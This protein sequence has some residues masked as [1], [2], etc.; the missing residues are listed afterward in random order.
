MRSIFALDGWPEVRPPAEGWLA[1]DGDGRP[2]VLAHLNGA[3]PAPVASN[4]TRTVHVVLAGRLDNRQE[5]RAT[6]TTRHGF[7]GDDD[8]ELVAHLY[9]ERGVQCLNALRGAF[10]L[11]VWDAPRRLMLIARDQ[12][13]LVPLFYVSEGTRLAAASLLPPLLALPGVGTSWDA[14]GLDAF[15]T[16]GTVP[17]PATLYPAVRQLGPGEMLLVEGRRVRVQRYW[18]LTFPERR[19]VTAELAGVLRT[20]VSDALRLRQAGSRWGLL[21]SGGLASAALLALAVA[22]RR[23]PVRAITA[24]LEAGDADEVRA[25]A[26]RATEA[27]V[28]HVVGRDEPDW[29]AAVDALLATH[30]GPVGG[31]D[32]AVLRLA[33]QYAGD[34]VDAVIAGVGAEEVFGG[35][36][37]AQAAARIVAYRRLPALVRESAQVW[38]RFAPG[39]LARG[40]R[41]LVVDERLAP[42]EMYARAV[43]L[44]LPEERADLYTPEWLS[45]LGE[46]RPW[47][48][49]TELFSAAVGAGATDTADAIH[50]AELVLR[51]PVRV[52]ALR[53]AAGPEIRLPFAD[54]RLAQFVASA[55]PAQRGTG[56][57]R[58]LLL[59][60]AVRD[61]LPV[62][63]LRRPHASPARAVS[64]ARGTLRDFVAETLAPDRV[65]AQGVFRPET[66]H[67]LW[68]EHCTGAQDH[69]ARLWALVLATRWLERHLARSSSAIR[70]AG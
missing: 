69:G 16:F 6:L 27:G 32:A 24:G 17:P 64:L 4:E 35:S 21:L 70:A 57:E 52:A 60:A 53:V 55:P 10:A 40:L 13:G 30:G 36:E 61:L 15:L 41:R 67:R 20:H 5:L 2:L 18:E 34:D 3:T 59:Q 25:A 58:Q 33:V 56:R 45:V 22:D 26:A 8:A 46:A 31:L 19:L 50:R 47:E 43:S 9:E 63:V 39:G 38:A 11:A 48:V 14:S 62:P 1:A 37:P 66:V 23:P 29:A 7:A 28:E 68:Q 12:L 51:L 44:F 54:H 42:L 49:L 65:G